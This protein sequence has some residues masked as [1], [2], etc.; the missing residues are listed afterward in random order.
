MSPSRRLCLCVCVACFGLV[1]RAT[2]CCIL[3]LNPNAVALYLNPSLSPSPSLSLSHTHLALPSLI[4]GVYLF[5]FISCCLSSL[6][7]EFRA[8]FV[9]LSSLSLFFLSLYLPL[10]QL[11]ARQTRA[12]CCFFC[13]AFLASGS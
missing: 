2:S 3:D 8:Q 4:F 10:S 1:T 13:L 12:T 7:I 9:E 5:D 11:L 6:L